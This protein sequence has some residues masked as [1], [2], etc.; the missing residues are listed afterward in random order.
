MPI[1]PALIGRPFPTRPYVVGAEAVHAFA[2][3]VRENPESDEAPTTFAIIP[4]FRGL[5]AFVEAA[6]IEYRNVVHADQKFAYDRPI[7]VGDTLVTTATADGIKP[8]G[9]NEMVTLRCELATDAGEHVCTATSTILVR[10]E[11]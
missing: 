7:R 1:D 11:A 6:G 3:A 5:D 8:L 2:T 4:A 10:A 9:A